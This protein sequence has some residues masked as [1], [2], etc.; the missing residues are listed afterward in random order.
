MLRNRMNVFHMTPEEAVCL[1]RH[2]RRGIVKHAY[3]GVPITLSSI[4]SRSGLSVPTVHKRL[5]NGWTV[6]QLLLA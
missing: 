4:A 1:P 2:S 3:R 6:E 5:K